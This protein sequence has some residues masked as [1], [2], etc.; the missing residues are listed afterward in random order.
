M[1]CNLIFRLIHFHIN[2]NQLPTRKANH[3]RSHLKWLV[4]Q[5]ETINIVFGSRIWTTRTYTYA[6]RKKNASQSHS[7]HQR[8]RKNRS[9]KCE[10]EQ[11]LSSTNENPLELVLFVLV[12]FG[13]RWQHRTGKNAHKMSL[14]ILGSAFYTENKRVKLVSWTRSKDLC[15]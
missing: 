15:V 10:R 4:T 5:I 9:S 2:F 8:K 6:A 12:I 7:K 14:S 1:P 13:A 3:Y 11:N